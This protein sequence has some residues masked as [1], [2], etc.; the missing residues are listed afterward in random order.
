[1]ADITITC[2]HCG[3]RITVSEYVE[4]ET[5]TCAKCREAVAVPRRVTEATPETKLKLAAPPPPTEEYLAQTAPARYTKPSRRHRHRGGSGLRPSTWGYIMF[6]VL[7]VALAY[8]RFIPD[9]MPSTQRE[10]LIKAAMAALVFLHVSVIAYAFADDALRG[11]LCAVIPGYSIYYLF[12]EA[13][14]YLLRA[15]V[16]ALLLVFGV[17]TTQFVRRVSYNFYVDASSWI[18][19]NDTLK[20]DRYPQIR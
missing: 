20:K 3:N 10:L 7:A 13:D 17:D 1:M 18:R 8:L 14:Q 4:A 19:D 6:V 2:R 9:A 12:A 15:V 5:L 11:V 16:A